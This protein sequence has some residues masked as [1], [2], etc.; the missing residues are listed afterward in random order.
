MHVLGALEL[1]YATSSHTKASFW[2][3]TRYKYATRL[4]S[5]DSVLGSRVAWGNQGVLK[6]GCFLS[7]RV[8]GLSCH[9]VFLSVL[10]HALSLLV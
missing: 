3:C 10:E 5:R 6:R 4:L 2:L 9:A 1:N 8:R 7:G